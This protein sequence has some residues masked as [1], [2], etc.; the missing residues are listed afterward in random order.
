MR[1]TDEP[2]DEVRTRIH[3]P[4]LH[5]HE[6]PGLDAAQIGHPLKAE[7]MPEPEMKHD[8]TADTQAAY[9]LKS[10]GFQRIPWTP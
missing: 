8:P 4:T 5:C 1:E 10:L 7:P 3:L 2:C 6:S 9:I